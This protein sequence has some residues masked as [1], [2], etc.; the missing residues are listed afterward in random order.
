MVVW[1]MQKLADVHL[2]VNTFKDASI[3]LL[4]K[5]SNSNMLNNH[6]LVE[7]LKIYN[8]YQ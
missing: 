1:A 4:P 3:I 8:A 5:G 6:F 7:E 2:L